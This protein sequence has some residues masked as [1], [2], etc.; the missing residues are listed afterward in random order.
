MCVCVCVF[1]CVLEGR[2]VYVDVMILYNTIHT[3][4][5]MYAWLGTNDNVNTLRALRRLCI[6][7]LDHLCTY[8]YSETVPMSTCISN[9]YIT[10]SIILIYTATQQRITQVYQNINVTLCDIS[11][12]NSILYTYEG[13]Y[14]L[15][16]KS[17]GFSISPYLYRQETCCLYVY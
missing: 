8:I 13:L 5:K 9:Q 16:V 7:Y 14:H 3:N 11:K 10:I 4:S 12:R 2:S 15:L 1:V 17:P 6:L